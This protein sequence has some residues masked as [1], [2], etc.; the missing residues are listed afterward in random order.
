MLHNKQGSKNSGWASKNNLKFALQIPA[1]DIQK[2]NSCLEREKHKSHK[3]GFSICYFIRIVC[4]SIWCPEILAGAHQFSSFKAIIDR[5]NGT[6]G[7]N[8]IEKP[9]FSLCFADYLVEFW[10]IFGCGVCDN[11]EGLDIIVGRDELRGN[12]V[13]ASDDASML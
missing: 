1:S 11:S 3:R 9:N 6:E 5:K 10:S 12:V 13:I 8:G 4:N 7:E 2:F